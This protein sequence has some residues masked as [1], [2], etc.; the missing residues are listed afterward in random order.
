[1][2]AVS[3]PRFAVSVLTAL[4]FCCVSASAQ[5]P[6]AI[7]RIG[8]IPFSG[9]S[10]TPGP[11]IE[12]FEQALRSAGYIPGKNIEI[13]Y[14][15]PLR[16]LNLIPAFVT[17]LLQLPRDVL[18]VGAYYVDRILKGAKPGDLPIEQPTEFEFVTNLKTAKQI[19]LTISPNVLARA[20]TVIR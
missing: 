10:S 13:G 8:V 20:D 7:P 4:L 3:R 14:R 5:Q 17:E 12:A 15:W 19:G 9:D 1:V 11:A 6:K 2:K 18:V 16:R